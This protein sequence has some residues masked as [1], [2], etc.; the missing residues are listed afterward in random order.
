MMRSSRRL[1]NSEG[2]RD[3]AGGEGM[4]EQGQGQD[5]TATCALCA[6]W[7]GSCLPDRYKCFEGVQALVLTR[8]V[9]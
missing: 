2:A 9:S 8:G 3:M 6:R 1:S 7:Y 5:V 4:R